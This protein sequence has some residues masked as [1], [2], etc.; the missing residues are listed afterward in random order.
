MI[1]PIVSMTFAV[2][3]FLFG[4]PVMLLAWLFRV[5]VSE[6]FRWLPPDWSSTVARR[7][8]MAFGGAYLGLVLGL[9]I[10]AVVMIVT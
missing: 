5:P 2:L 7:F 6:P 4:W 1:P 8:A 3:S 10:M 9:A